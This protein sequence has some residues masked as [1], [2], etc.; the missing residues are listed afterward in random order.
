MNSKFYTLPELAKFNSYGLW[1][2]KRI[3][4]SKHGNLY[5]TLIY[6]VN[7]SKSGYT[8]TEF[9][10]IVHIK[11]NDA[12]RNL[13][14]QKRLQRQKDKG[15]YIYYSIEV[16]CFEVQLSNRKQSTALAQSYC[17]PDDKNIIISVLVAIIHNDT[18]TAK[19]LHKVLK[20]GQIEVSQHQISS[21]ITHYGLK[22]K[23]CN[24]A[25]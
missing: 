1:S 6:I 5:Q 12:L 23:T 16:Q 14:Q 20:I 13:Y 15:S 24:S 10:A 21:I 19:K 3:L 7:K 17:F 9:S 4:F 22:K 2:Y 8:S 11:I 25:H 18:L